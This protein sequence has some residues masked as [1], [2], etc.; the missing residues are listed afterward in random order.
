MVGLVTHKIGTSSTANIM[1]DYIA[2]WWRNTAAIT[3]I[4][5]FPSG[6][7]FVDGSIVALYGIA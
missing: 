7:A 4:D 1:V 3:Q 6:N 5:V 2:G